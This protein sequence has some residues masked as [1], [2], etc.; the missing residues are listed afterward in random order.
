MPMNKADYPPDWPAISRRVREAAG[1]KCEWCGVP[2]GEVGARDQFGRWHS[3][4]DM[5]GMNSSEGFAL[6]PDGWP[7]TVKIVLTVAHVD[8]DKTNNERNNL[9]ALCQKCHL[10]HDRPHHLAKTAET[11]RRR[12]QEQAAQRGQ[13]VMELSR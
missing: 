5:E 8:R 9:A 10:N 12:R 4:D 13:L 11:I 2:N 7:K 6:W 1:Q 3:E